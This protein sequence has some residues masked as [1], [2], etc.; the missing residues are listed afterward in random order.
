MTY[1]WVNQRTFNFL[2][3][4]ITLLN[5]ILWWIYA[6][7]NPHRN[8]RAG[9]QQIKNLHRCSQVSLSYW[10]PPD[11]KRPLIFWKWRGTYGMWPSLLHHNWKR[12]IFK[13]YIVYS[14]RIVF[15]VF[16]HKILSATRTCGYRTGCAPS[17]TVNSQ[18]RK[19]CN[20]NSYN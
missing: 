4:L 16:T 2:S 19:F 14:R 8:I 6:W 7:N 1:L 17:A 11:W 3:I 9:I 15:S 12:P 18:T 5:S 10:C 13:S 20:R